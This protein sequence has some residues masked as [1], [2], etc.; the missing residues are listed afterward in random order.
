MNKINIEIVVMIQ[1]ISNKIIMKKVIYIIHLRSK[2]K[3]I[4]KYLVRA[5]ICSIL[6][7]NI[8]RQLNNF[9]NSFMEKTIII[10]IIKELKIKYSQL[11]LRFKI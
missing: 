10:K 5:Q 6:Y 8:K 1:I 7:L 2:I 9:L 11:E 4:I 3:Q